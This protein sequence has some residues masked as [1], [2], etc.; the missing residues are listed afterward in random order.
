MPGTTLAGYQKQITTVKSMA[1]KKTFIEDSI[2][3]NFAG[4]IY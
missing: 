2:A 3:W 4:E 1:R